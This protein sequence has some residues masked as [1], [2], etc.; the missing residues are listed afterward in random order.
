[1]EKLPLIWVGFSVEGIPYDRAAYVFEMDPN[2]VG[3]PSAWLG[4]N[5]ACLIIASGNMD[6]CYCL[7][8]VGKSGHFLSMHRVAAY[9]SS[10]DRIRWPSMANGQIKFIHFSCGEELD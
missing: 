9:G 10:D 5:K 2:L 7:S 1:V 3:S 4:K 8:S 6:F